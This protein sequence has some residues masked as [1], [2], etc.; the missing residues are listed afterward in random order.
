MQELELEG[1]GRGVKKRKHLEKRD[2]R[3]IFNVL[4]VSFASRVGSRIFLSLYPVMVTTASTLT[5]GASLSINVPSFP[6]I[7]QW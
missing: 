1:T 7:F 4:T 6:V 2:R 5:R 3:P